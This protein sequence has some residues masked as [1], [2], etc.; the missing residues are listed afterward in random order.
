MSPAAV[1]AP[2]CTEVRPESWSVVSTCRLPEERLLSATADR[3]PTCIE[4]SAFR[5][6][7]PRL[8]S[9]DALRLDT[10]VALR[11]FTWS[12]VRSPSA[13]EVR[14]FSCVAVRPFSC[15]EV[16]ESMT[17]APF[18]VFAAAPMLER[19]APVSPL[20]AVAEIALIC[21]VCS[22][23]RS[24]VLRADS[25]AALST[26]T[27]AEESA[28]TSSVVKL[29]IWAVDRRAVSVSDRFPMLDDISLIPASA[30]RLFLAASNG[31]RIGDLRTD[32]RSGAP[33]I[34][35]GFEH[36]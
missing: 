8:P 1:S 14:P 9:V 4:V 22:T 21:C 30:R 3:L 25:C 7:V 6:S 32:H 36:R 15:V 35:H 5:L 11:L 13:V 26:P 17:E 34:R 19:A 16:R 20:K 12:V 28:A 24:A 33:R 27:C 2:T 23:W 29:A 10:C 31:F 18:S